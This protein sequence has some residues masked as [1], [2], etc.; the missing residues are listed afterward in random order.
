M[1]TVNILP[2]VASAPCLKG[3]KAIEITHFIL[4]SFFINM[5][6][7]RRKMQAGIIEGGEHG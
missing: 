7:E 1:H 6:R 4:L 5:T 2:C 3:S